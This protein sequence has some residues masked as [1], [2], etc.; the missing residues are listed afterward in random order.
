[1]NKRLFRG[2][3]IT[4]ALVALSSVTAWAQ[5]PASSPT[6]LQKDRQDIRQDTKDI[7]SD[8]H[9]VRSDVKDRN[10]D[11]RDLRA[12]KADGASSAEL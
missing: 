4:L 9:D 5:T 8:R 1:M 7:R 11:V 2:S 10:A 6:D 3:L 12:D